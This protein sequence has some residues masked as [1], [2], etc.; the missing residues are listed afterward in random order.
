MNSYLNHYGC[1][2]Y[3]QVR[4]ECGFSPNKLTLKND[5]QAQ[6]SNR[7]IEELVEEERNNLFKHET[8]VMLRRLPPS[9]ITYQRILAI[10]KILNEK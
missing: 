10:E 2:F 8:L 3:N 7:T 5:L 9:Y 6:C 4:D 1:P